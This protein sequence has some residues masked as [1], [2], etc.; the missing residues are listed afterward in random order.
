MHPFL[1]GL[2][3]GLLFIFSLGPGFF[4]LIQTSVQKGFKRAILLAV[5]ISLS[6]ILYVILAIMGVASLL[7][8]PKIRLWLGVIG[9]VVLIVYGVYSWFKKPKLYKDEVEGKKDLSALK[10]LFKGFILNGFNPFIVVFWVS[11][12]GVVA[13]KY[14][15]P[16]QSQIA[17]FAG[18]LTTILTTDIIKAFVAHRLRSA[19]TPKKILILNRSVGIILILFGFRMIYFLVDNYMLN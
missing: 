4:A 5:G 14:N 7:E 1:T 13:S 17:F 12:I 10:Y 16:F 2:V 3:F 8:Q 19:I 18:V 15:Y 11:I 9:T 6:D